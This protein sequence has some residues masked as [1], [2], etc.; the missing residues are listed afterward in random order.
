MTSTYLSPKK[1]K[2]ERLK[3]WRLKN[4]FI[5]KFSAKTMTENI[6][7]SSIPIPKVSKTAKM[8][9]KH[10]KKQDAMGGPQRTAMIIAKLARTKNN[11]CVVCLAVKPTTR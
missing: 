5:S 11:S 9:V 10:E 1:N 6:A 4:E 2:K 7:K 3:I 8:F